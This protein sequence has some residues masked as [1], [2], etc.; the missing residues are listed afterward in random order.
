[1]RPGPPVD[2]ARQYAEY[3]GCRRKFLLGCFAEERE[4]ACDACDNC[5]SG[6]TAD[7]HDDGRRRPFPLQSTV[8]HNEW[9]NGVVT[10]YENDIV[11]VLFE[12]HGYKSLS[13]PLVEEKDLLRT[14]A[15]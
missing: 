7:N 13:I 15:P 3:R 14:V 10:E 12:E 1:M 6:R 9:G 5:D 2:M 4:G 11:T 8:S